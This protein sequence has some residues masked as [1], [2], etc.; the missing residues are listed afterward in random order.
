M[1]ERF[2]GERGRWLTTLALQDAFPEAFKS[3]RAMLFPKEAEEIGM[4]KG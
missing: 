2:V 3:I 4:P 1:P